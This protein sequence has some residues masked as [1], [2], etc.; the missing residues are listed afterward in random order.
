MG[1]LENLSLSALTILG[2]AKTA[3]KV[4]SLCPGN[5]FIF[6]NTESLSGIYV[7]V[8]EADINYGD[9]ASEG[10]GIYISTLF[11]VHFALKLDLAFTENSILVELCFSTLTSTI[12]S[13]LTETSSL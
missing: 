5:Y 2:K 8:P 3:F 13:G 7:A 12:K 1:C 4:I 6:H 10:T 9:W 11:A